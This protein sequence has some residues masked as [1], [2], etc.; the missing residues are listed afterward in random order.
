MPD[1]SSLL[2]RLQR[3][4]PRENHSPRENF[5]TEVFTWVLEKCPEFAEKFVEELNTRAREKDQSVR[6]DTDPEHWEWKTQ[7][8]LKDSSR[9]DIVGTPSKGP[10]IIIEVKYESEAYDEQLQRYKEKY[11]EEHKNSNVWVFL[12]HPL[13]NT[14]TPEKNENFPQIEPIEWERVDEIAREVKDSYER[15]NIGKSDCGAVKIFVLNEFIQLLDELG[16]S[17]TIPPEIFEELCDNDADVQKRAT[18]RMKRAFEG[19]SKYLNNDFT[20]DKFK[21]VNTCGRFGIACLEHNQNP[22]FF[23]GLIHDNWRLENFYSTI[24]IDNG[25]QPILFAILIYTYDADWKKYNCEY[26]KQFCKKLKTKFCAEGYECYD[27]IHGSEYPF[28]IH[29]K[30][31]DIKEN[32]KSTYAISDIVKGIYENLLKCLSELLGHDELKTL[33]NALDE[34]E[35]RER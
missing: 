2:V 20:N 29:K 16:L 32:I 23:A 13:W 33:N 12:L 5:L 19:A 14:F 10:H 21:F 22:G 34:M 31:D 11:E 30:F 28:I 1:N 26:F 9:P 25:A 18:E 27:E 15:N 3:Y 8:T 17:T 6:F 35:R 4:A 7:V 24:K